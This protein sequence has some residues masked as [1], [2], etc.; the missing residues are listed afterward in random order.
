[1]ENNELLE[2]VLS[3]KNIDRFDGDSGVENLSKVARM[4]GYRDSFHFGQFSDGCIGDFLEFLRDNSGCQEAIMTWI[5]E[6]VDVWREELES[7]L[8]D[9]EEEGEEA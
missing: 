1:M 2:A 6:N 4:L 3:Q 7:Y 8:S 5:E 9:E